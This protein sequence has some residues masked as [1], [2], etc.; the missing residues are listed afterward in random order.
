[1]QSYRSKILYGRNNNNIIRYVDKSMIIISNNNSRKK[2]REK[3]KFSINIDD[4]YNNSIIPNVTCGT[5]N[6]FSDTILLCVRILQ[7]EP[8]K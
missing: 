3:S 8:A 1:M 4:V 6:D 7:T 2:A 5:Y